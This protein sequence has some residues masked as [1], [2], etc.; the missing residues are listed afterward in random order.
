[1]REEEAVEETEIEELADEGAGEEERDGGLSGARA[2]AA[3]L[4]PFPFEADEPAAAAAA[5]PVEED[6]CPPWWC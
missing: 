6:A 4:L 2:G 1:M 3:P 5:I